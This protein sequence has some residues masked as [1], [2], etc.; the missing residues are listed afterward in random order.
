[1]APSKAFL[2]RPA[3]VALRIV[4]ESIDEVEMDS[5]DRMQKSVDKVK[6]NLV[7]IRTGRASVN[8]LDRVQ[9]EYY[10]AMTPLNQMASISVPNSQQLMVEP[11]DKTIVG[12]VVKAIFASDLGL[13]PNEDDSGKIY[14]NVPTIT[15]D[16][17]KELSKQC[18][19]MGEE[20]KVAIRNVRRDGVDAIKK[21]EKDSVISK[22][23]CADGLDTMQKLTDRLVKEIETIVSKK[24]KEIMTV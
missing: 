22:D 10:G 24:E 9:V 7:S 20:G 17:R 14:L 3:T 21:L 13:T 6:E 23:Q 18:K 19:A 5:E 11:Y 12:D 15:E 2:A 16:R 1:V 4:F 8:M